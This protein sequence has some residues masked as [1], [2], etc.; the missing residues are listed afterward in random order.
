MVLPRDVALA[1]CSTVMPASALLVK[2]GVVS[3]VRLSVSELP[4]SDA[5]VRSGVVGDGEPDASAAI[6]FPSTRI[7]I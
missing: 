3:V 6:H 2:D 4:V 1:N 5:G 7:W